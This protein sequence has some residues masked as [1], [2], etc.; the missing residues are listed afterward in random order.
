MRVGRRLGC[1]ALAALLVAEVLV[2]AAAAQDARVNAPVYFQQRTGLLKDQGGGSA[3]FSARFHVT[4]ANVN[5]GATLLPVVRGFKYRLV[6]CKAISIGGAAGGVTT[7]DILATQA[8]A[9]V[10]L[11]AYAQASLT[12]STVLEAGGSGAAVLADGASFAQNDVSTAITIGK[13][14]SDVTTAS[15]I[16]VIISYVLE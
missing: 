7:V 6:A 9:S 14:G 5:A 8:T 15:H 16:D 13:T 10:K 3:I 4:I 2:P 1:I 12:Q 11:V